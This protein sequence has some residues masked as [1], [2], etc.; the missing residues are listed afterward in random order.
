MPSP[1]FPA[2]PWELWVIAPLAPL[3]L[4]AILLERTFVYKTIG[5][6]SDYY[7]AAQP[8]DVTVAAFPISVFTLVHAKLC[9]V[10]DQK[11]ILLGSPFIQG[12]YDGPTIPPG[13]APHAIDDPRRGEGVE[14]PIHDVSL[15]VRGPAV[16]AL[17]QTFQLHWDVAKPGNLNP[18]IPGPPI[19]SVNPPEHL[20]TVQVIRTLPKATFTSDPELDKNGETQCLEA[21]LRAIENAQQLIYLENQYFTNVAI[22]NALI[23]A[24]NDPA[25]PNLEII[26][27]INITPDIPFYPS[28]QKHRIEEIFEQA[29]AA[30]SRIEF[31]AAFTHEAPSGAHTKGRIIPNYFHSKVGIVDNLWATIGSANL[32]GNSLD[33]AQLLHAL[34]ESRQTTSNM[35]RR[36]AVSTSARANSREFDP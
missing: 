19:T 36:S 17:Q 23:A 3:L 29:G 5:D 4:L 7:F 18:A 32:D 24:L 6:V 34:R 2:Q 31:F 35:S 16:A 25:R 10:D 12:Y 8:N 22:A 1:A 27:L 26:V 11:A 28:W 21:Y 9:V 20:A 33:E 13:S 14:F 30:A 15:A